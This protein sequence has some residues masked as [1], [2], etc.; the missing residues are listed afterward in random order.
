MFLLCKAARTAAFI[1]TTPASSAAVSQGMIPGKHFVRCRGPCT[2]RLLAVVVANTMRRAGWAHSIDSG[3]RS[4]F[5]PSACVLN[6]DLIFS[7]NRYAMHPPSYHFLSTYHVP[8][9]GAQASVCFSSVA[10]SPPGE[11]IRITDGQSRLRSWIYSILFI[12][13]FSCARGGG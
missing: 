13:C 11:Y 1:T 6:C 4:F 8:G 5:S 9:L 7:L 2:C 12:G 10:T 3:P